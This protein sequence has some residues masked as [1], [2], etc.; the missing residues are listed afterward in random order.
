MNLNNL[1][2]LCS[3]NEIELISLFDLAW[4]ELNLSQKINQ[5][6]QVQILETDNLPKSV[7]SKCFS[8]VLVI[9]NYYESVQKAQEILQNIII[10]HETFNWPESEI[11]LS[12][13]CSSIIRSDSFTFDQ[14]IDDDLKDHDLIKLE[15]TPGKTLFY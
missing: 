12:S 4:N 3:N 10:E 5:C 14:L 11:S 8:Q 2:R 13:P 15:P 1:C 9:Y 7:C 6:L